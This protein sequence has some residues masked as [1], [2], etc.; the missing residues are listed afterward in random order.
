M[1]SRQ[2]FLNLNVRLKLINGFLLVL[3]GLIHDM[4]SLLSWLPVHFRIDFK[5]L[6]ITFAVPWR[7]A[8]DYISDMLTPMG[9]FAALDPRVD[10]FWSLQ[11]NIESQGD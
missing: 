8:L 1:I 10:P 5:I 4:T 9:P 2:L 3:L 6:L 7:F 11:S